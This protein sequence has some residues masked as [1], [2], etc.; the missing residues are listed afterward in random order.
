MSLSLSNDRL[1]VTDGS[2]TVFDSDRN[3]PHIVQSVS[4]TL[5][6][7][8]TTIYNSVVNDGLV[9]HMYGGGNTAFYYLTKVRP[10]RAFVLAYFKINSLPT[11]TN[12]QFNLFTSSS[13][14]IAG[15]GGLLLRTWFAKH[16]S[17]YKQYSN[18]YIKQ[19]N[20]F[21]GSQQ[22]YAYVGP[23]PDPVYTDYYRLY[24]Q[25][26][27]SVG[28]VVVSVSDDSLYIRNAPDGNTGSFY[29][30]TLPSTGGS[31]DYRVY[32]GTF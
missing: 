8:N 11:G 22:I 18:P 4:G 31:I 23:D 16:P 27:M 3:T 30:K 20:N 9:F 14:W 25:T 15:S 13:R 32:L 28:G 19:L 6:L 29:Y 10:E 7:V 5:N 24:I 12:T 26:Q 21:Q 2:A 1:L 17:S